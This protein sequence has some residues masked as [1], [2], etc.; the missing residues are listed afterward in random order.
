MRR[1]EPHGIYVLIPVWYVLAVDLDKQA[2]RM[3]RMD[4]IA[5]PRPLARRFTTSRAVVEEMIAWRRTGSMR[6][7]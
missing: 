1:V 7:S 3:F 4:R 6:A 5:N 2:E